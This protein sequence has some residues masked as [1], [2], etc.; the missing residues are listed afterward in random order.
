MSKTIVVCPQTGQWLQQWDDEYYQ[1]L[2]EYLSEQGD[3]WTG[4][5]CE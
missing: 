5:D 4:F 2:E 1:E 3:G